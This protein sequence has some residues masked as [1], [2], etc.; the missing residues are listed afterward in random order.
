MHLHFQKLTLA[1]VWRTGARPQAPGPLG[2]PL[3]PAPLGMTTIY[4]IIQH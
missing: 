3:Q 2:F 1:A 4:A